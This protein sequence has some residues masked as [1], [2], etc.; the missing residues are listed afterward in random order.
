MRFYPN[1]VPSFPFEPTTD[2]FEVQTVPGEQGEGIV[3]LASFEPGET[4]A[5]FTGFVVPK[6]SIF[7][8]QLGPGRHIHD[9]YFMGK[10]LHHCAPNMTVDLENLSF[11]A[12]TPIRPGDV[13]SI[14]Y[15]VTEERLFAPFV[16]SC[17]A[18]NCRRIIKGKNVRQ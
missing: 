15:E 17:G 13:I 3:S 16:C 8:L 1:E 7:T 10:I 5:A 11:T 18:P 4:V 12:C 14:D 9:P 6:I 2:R